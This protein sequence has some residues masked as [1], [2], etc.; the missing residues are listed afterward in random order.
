MGPDDPTDD[1]PSP[2]EIRAAVERITASEVF[3]RSPQIVAFL[4]FVVE[5]VLQGKSDRIKA[6]TIGIEVLRRDTRFDP[7]IDPIVRVEGS[8]L[9]RAI[10][11]YYSGPGAADPVGIDLP[12]GSYVPSF[13]HRPVERP[14]AVGAIAGTTGRIGR[15]S[16]THTT[17]AAAALAVLAGAA[18]GLPWLLRSAHNPTVPEPGTSLTASTFQPGG[19][20]PTLAVAPLEISGSPG[21]GSPSAQSLHRRLTGAFA[22][23]DTVHVLADGN[24][25]P[26]RPTPDYRVIGSI[27]HRPD[28]LIDIGFRLVDADGKVVWSRA[29]ERSL[30]SDSQEEIEDS[31]VAELATILLQPYGVIRSRDLAR[32]FGEN[33]EGSRY[34][35]ILEAS[36][37]SR[38]LSWSIQQQRAQ[39]C[40]QHWIGVDPGLAVAYPYF[41]QIYIQN[42]LYE[43]VPSA[44]DRAPLDHALGLARRGVELGP[45]N[46]RAHHI[47]MLT[48]FYR[49][50]FSAA[51]AAG[52]RALALNPY[53]RIIAAD[54]GTSLIQSGAIETGLPMLLRNVGDSQ[55][56]LPRHI[57][58][59]FIGNYLLNNMVDAVHYADQLDDGQ[60]PYSLLANTLILI[61]RQEPERARDLFERLTLV[62]PGWRDL[63]RELAKHF[64]RPSHISRLTAELGTVSRPAAN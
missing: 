44:F 32:M 26:S 63:D 35:C 34:R 49:K 3:N 19:E 24:A 37:A 1:A 59:L 60:N 50:E 25:E 10:E 21:P 27:A 12:R 13:R 51:F 4:R 14:A 17:A 64:G 43:P 30:A 22:R 33:P 20:M 2:D 54:Y 5:S 38:R 28:R 9:R 8:R 61:W 23:F 11:R 6:Y 47:L 36:D 52:D 56:L 57:F 42:F 41:A 45:E 58:G 48:R 16:R 7:Q 46:A 31:I 15:W 55:I 53:D 40:L 29:F 62:Q 18:L 39:Q